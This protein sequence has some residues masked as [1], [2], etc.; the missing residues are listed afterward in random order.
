MNLSLSEDIHKKTIEDFEIDESKSPKGIIGKGAF[1]FVKL[2]KDKQT[3]V[4]YAMKIV[5]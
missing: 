3:G 1:S 2:V 4:H 5:M